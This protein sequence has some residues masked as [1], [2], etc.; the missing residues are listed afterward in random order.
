MKILISFQNEQTIRDMASFK[1]MPVLQWIFVFLLYS[2]MHIQLLFK[3]IALV[4]YILP[5]YNKS[6][7]KQLN[8]LGR[9][10]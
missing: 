6:R 9:V 3:I 5:H 1:N 8:L 10:L 4:Q 7:L 2:K